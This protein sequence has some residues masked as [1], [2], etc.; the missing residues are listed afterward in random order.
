MTEARYCEYCGAAL[1][2]AEALY[3]PSC[4]ASVGMVSFTEAIRLAWQRYFVFG[5]RSTRAEYWWWALF[6][7][8]VFLTLSVV[9]EMTGLFHAQTGIGLFN[10]L[11]NLGVLSPTL[12]LGARRLHD[13]NRSGWWQLML[14]GSGFVVA[15]LIPLLVIVPFV[16]LIVWAI[17]PG[18]RGPN[19]Y[20]PDP[21]QATSQ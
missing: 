15:T 10:V 17:K 6:T 14:F 16:V 13:I 21:R 9:E 3:C 19:K 5:G 18:D 11:F 8:I 4:G 20:G 2:S 1:S 7:T 12:A